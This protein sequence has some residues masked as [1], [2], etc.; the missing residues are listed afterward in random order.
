VSKKTVDTRK[1]TVLRIGQLRRNAASL[2]ETHE[3]FNGRR[4][5][6]LSR[7]RV[8]AAPLSPVL[9]DANV[10]LLGLLIVILVMG[11][12]GYWPR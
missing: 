11:S 6:K 12:A 10:L 8:L 7:P 9:R 4:Q 2:T 5:L 1:K 3:M